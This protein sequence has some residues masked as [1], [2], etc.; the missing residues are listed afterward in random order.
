LLPGHRYN[1]VPKN[2]KRA[3]DKGIKNRAT[4]LARK[5]VEKGKNLAKNKAARRAVKEMVVDSGML[6]LLPGYGAA[7]NMVKG[8]RKISKAARVSKVTP[9]LKK[10]YTCLT[11]PFSPNATGACIPTGGN[12]PSARN[13]GFV[14]FDAF[15]G[16]GGMGFVA[17]S[18]TASNQGPAFYYTN[19][20]F[21]GVTT[22]ILTAVNT[23]SV[24][25][26]PSAMPNNRWTT[27]QLSTPS[28]QNPAA[29]SRCVGGGFRMMYTGTNL[30]LSG[31]VY[32]YT[33]PAHQTAVDDGSG[34]PFTIASLGALQETVVFPVQ[35]EPYELSLYPV[36]EK[37]LDYHDGNSILNHLYP[38]SNNTNINGFTYNSFGL[39][40][41]APTT[42]VVFTGVP[43]QSVH[44]EYGLHW[45]SVGPVTEGMRQASDSDVAG[46]DQ[47]MCALAGAQVCASSTRESF[48]SCL[49][50]EF[51]RIKIGSVE[52]ASL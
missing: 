23:F 50:K 18:P 37:E 14:R 7:S 20:A 9:C 42:V 28:L 8:V 31:M 1:S 36:E 27:A 17:F 26:L 49:R 40:V 47:M 22:R 2:Q 52:S 6:T 15:V 39:D 43:G 25:V 41:G 38:W 44:F 21:A 11:D 16:T 10:W 46:V 3:S 24:G 5:I 12:V 33:S 30:N 48:T 45:E 51:A 19:V 4:S 13:F 34:N 32:T 35:R 29:S